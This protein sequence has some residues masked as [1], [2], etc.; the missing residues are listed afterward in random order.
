MV[1]QTT[2]LGG[3]AS[4]V[5]V[6]RVALGPDPCP[7]RAMLRG[8]QGRDRRAPARDEMFL[9]SGEFYAMDMKTGNLEMLARFYERYPEYAEKTF[10]SVKGAIR[11]RA[12]DCSA[13]SLRASVDN[14]LRA[15]GPIKKLDLFQ[16]ARIDHRVP[17]E[18]MMQTLAALVKEGKFAHIGL[19]ECSA[20]TLRR[21]HKVHPVTAVEIEVSPFSFE[22]KTKAVI[23]AAGELGVSVI[24]YS[25]LGRGIIA[26]KIKSAADLEEG[27]IR[28]RYS[29]FK[30]ENL[31]GNLP[32][33]E[34]LEG[35]AK[36]KGITVAQ[37]CIAWVAAQGSSV[38][39][40]P[41]SSKATRTLENLQAGE[42]VLSPTELTELTE[43]V[44]KHGVKGDRG[45]GL[46]DEQMHYWG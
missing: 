33:V 25:P 11:D 35:M 21:A 31:K 6:G 2:K 28:F 36:N 7:R 13:A 20:D 46:T 39:P 15:L 4:D 37:L 29:R 18:E 43:T 19:S 27:D 34:A 17:V 14:I 40:V 38:I 10:L 1:Q 5:T 23:A 9:N 42:V 12:P 22:E 30:E 45:A 41:G 32:I 16:P 8:H 44:A 24:A 26:G 3:T